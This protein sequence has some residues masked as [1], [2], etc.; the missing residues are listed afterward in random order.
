MRSHP[1]DEEAI[2]GQA[3]RF[4]AARAVERLPEIA[5]V[6]GESD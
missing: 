5:R 4:S 3:R 1:W 2:R 6:S